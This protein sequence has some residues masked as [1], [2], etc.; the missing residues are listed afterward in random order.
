MSELKS[1]I[2]KASVVLVPYLK[3]SSITA[4]ELITKSLENIGIDD[5]ELGLKILESKSTTDED[6][7][8]AIKTVGV[9]IPLPRIRIVLLILKGEDPFEQKQVKVNAVDTNVVE[10][11]VKRL[12]K[13][14]PIGQW[15]DQELLQN[16]SKNCP[17]QVEEELTKRSKTRPC[18]IFT[19]NNMILLEPSLELLRQARH[20]NTPT[21][22]Y[23]GNETVKVF[24]IG[25]FPMNMFY[26]CPIHSHVLL[27]N[28][29]C[30]ECGI[31][32]KDFDV[33]KEKYIFLRLISEEDK[34]QPI[35]LRAYLEK[36]F[37]E[38]TSM[39]PKI[40]LKYKDL[41]EEDNLP[42]LKRRLSNTKNGDPFRIVHKQ[43]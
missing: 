43:Y 2:K 5:S 11:I 13:Q 28:G 6:F 35:A 27:V 21:T 41:K 30:E 4:E 24:K 10:E 29:Y 34:I 19:D 26:E 32:Y 40:F 8:T 15:S 17:L 33:Q 23:V 16:Y 31:A 25:D 20:T 3:S 37:E 9:N 38:L 1:R 7:D 39:F 36:S 22:Y 18:I 12:E 14:K 42:K